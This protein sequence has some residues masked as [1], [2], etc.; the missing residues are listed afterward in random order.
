MRHHQHAGIAGRLH[1]GSDELHPHPDCARPD[2]RVA[3]FPIASTDGR[4]V[5]SLEGLT[6]VPTRAGAMRIVAVPHV[7]HGLALGDEIAVADWD[8]EPLARGELALALAGTVRCAAA[9]GR[10]WRD[11]AAAIDSAAG[12]IGTCWF[13]A[14]GESAVAASVPRDALGAVFEAL[15]H[16]AATDRLRWEYATPGRHQD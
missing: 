9:D 10:T 16:D 14:I 12:G 6:C 3:W 1:P 15:Q 2:A 4:D 8:G 7:A 13:D 5:D 11:L